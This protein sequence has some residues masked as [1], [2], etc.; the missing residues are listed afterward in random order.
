MKAEINKETGVLQLIPENKMEGYL[1][2]GWMAHNQN[3][4]LSHHVKVI[5]TK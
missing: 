1:L 3:N 4:L 2:S 5:E